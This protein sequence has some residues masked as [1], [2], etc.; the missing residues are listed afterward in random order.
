MTLLAREGKENT[1][2]YD[3]NLL[4]AVI[5][6]NWRNHRINDIYLLSCDVKPQQMGLLAFFLA[7][8]SILEEEL[9]IIQLHKGS[10]EQEA[11]TDI[12]FPVFHSNP[13]WRYRYS[14]LSDEKTKAQETE[15]EYIVTHVNLFGFQALHLAAAPSSSHAFL[16]LVVQSLCF[17]GS[18]GQPFNIQ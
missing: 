15:V 18:S 17:F 5:F 14:H 1:N 6:K 7:N 9:V 11:F 8:P 16:I 10:L 3:I 2:L 12:L 13:A 4:E